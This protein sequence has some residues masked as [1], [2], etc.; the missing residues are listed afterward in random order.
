MTH[1]YFCSTFENKFICR[2]VENSEATNLLN[3]GIAYDE[4]NKIV[5]L[6]NLIKREIKVFKV[7]ENNELFYLNTIYTN[8][9]GDNVH[10]LK[11]QEGNTLLTA[12]VI[13][14]FKDHMDLGEKSKILGKISEDKNLM[15][16][17]IRVKIPKNADLK[18]DNV[19]KEIE[20]KIEVSVMQDEFKGV[21]SGFEFNGNV[22]LTSWGDDGILVCKS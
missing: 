3:N 4:E 10:V 12:G 15:F 17:A 6:S 7:Q 18:N 13:G 14:R 22:Y 11:D 5:Y 20:G 8:F 21:S 2:K 9:A 19:I 1:V 16:G